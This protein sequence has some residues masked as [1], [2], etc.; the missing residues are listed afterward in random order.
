LK[1]NGDD[2]AVVVFTLDN[3]I[4]TAATNEVALSYRQIQ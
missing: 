1:K 4:V 2:R 3:V